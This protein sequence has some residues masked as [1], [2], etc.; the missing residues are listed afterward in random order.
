MKRMRHRPPFADAEKSLPVETWVELRMP[1]PIM[2]KRWDGC[3]AIFLRFAGPDYIV[4]EIDRVERIVSK[5]FWAEL[6]SQKRNLA[7][8]STVRMPS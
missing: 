1:E 3:P 6:P 4:I 5:Q 8:E 2:I 7:D